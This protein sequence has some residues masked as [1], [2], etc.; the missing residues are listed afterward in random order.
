MKRKE[1]RLAIIALRRK[2]NFIL[3]KESNK[4]KP[5]RKPNNSENTE[6][7]YYPCTN[8]LGFFKKS[9][10][11]RHKKKC[12]TLT[13]IKKSQCRTNHLSEA[14]TFIAATGLLG[15][16]L[17]KSRLKAEVFSIMKADKISFAAKCDPLICLY[18]ESYLSKHKRKQMNVVASNKV[19]EIAKLLLAL[20]KFSTVKWCI[21]F[22]RPDMYESIVTATKIICGFDANTRTFKAS[23]LALHFG[24]N[25][26][27]LCDV[28]KK[29]VITKNP[30]IHITN[31]S[32][33]DRKLKEICELRD[34][35]QCHWCNDVSSLANKN[36][37]E[38]K[39][40]KPQLVPLTEDIERFNDY[41]LTV[42]SKAFTCLKNKEA[43]ETNYK[44]LAECTLCLLV[45][46]NRK[47]IG[48]VQFLDI[49]TYERDSSIL[50]QEEFDRCLTQ[51]EKN[52]CSFF[53]RVVVFGKGSKPVPLLF[54]KQMQMYIPLLLDVRK[55]TNI[56]PKENRYIFANPGSASRWMSGSYVVRKFAYKCGASRPELLTS[57]RFRKQIAT[58]LQ[59]MSF[60]N[61]EMEQIAR[62][63]GH[64]EKTHKEFYRLTED[65]YQTAKVAKEKGAK[66]DETDGTG[67]EI[68]VKD[69][70]SRED[71]SSRTSISVDY[72]HLESNSNEPPKPDITN[73][74]IKPQKR[75]RW[76]SEEK[77]LMLKYF[78][79]NITKCV[80]PRKQDCLDFI[81]KNES[82]FKKEDWIRVKTFV[83]NTY[84][85][86]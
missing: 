7:V 60:Q 41:L 55:E 25:L 48:E 33:R 14:Q 22:L 37:N 11:W 54:T 20:Q 53:K 24:T 36:L 78:Q 13:G 21:D 43:V 12:N 28:A 69:A 81:N 63:M 29:A 39:I 67:N 3:N 71:K 75:I 35:I 62:F 68:Q 57:T 16:Y 27:F 10:L 59:L 58:I 47:R 76:S 83:Y 74:K 72:P 77:Q 40:Q 6:G 42:A 52:M 1:R 17:E 44:I 79:K 2:W 5:V 70:E 32:G 45:V 56:V 82:I 65:T 51:F 8:C 61:D 18:G 84:R 85:L 66:I 46:F 49:N 50:N 86:Q 4:L 23:S 38:S 31:E 9:Y 73:K 64:T 19:R 26:K 30:L 80:A 15:N 34:I